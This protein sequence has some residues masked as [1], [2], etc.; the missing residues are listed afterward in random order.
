MMKKAYQVGYCPG[1]FDLFHMGHL[2]LLRRSKERCEYLIAGVVN[3]DLF[4]FFKGK[5]PYV[6]FEQRLA[7]VEAIKYVDKAVEVSLQNTDKIDAWKLYRYDCH[8]AGGDHAQHWAEEKQYL[9]TVGANMEF[10]PYTQS[11]SSTKIRELIE[12]SLL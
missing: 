1:S 8:F 4:R 5:D 2:N 12:R 7:I 3:D 9:Q 6:P 10:F 11:I